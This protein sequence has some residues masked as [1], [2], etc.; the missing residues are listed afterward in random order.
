MTEEEGHVHGYIRR[1]LSML[2]RMVVR[3]VNGVYSIRRSL[4]GE[5]S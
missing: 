1:M 5:C 3:P 4:H 2:H